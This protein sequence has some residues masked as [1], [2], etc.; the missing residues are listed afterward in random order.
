L[1][2]T[3]VPIGTGTKQEHQWG[4]KKDSLT[5]KS[6]CPQCAIK[7]NPQMDNKYIAVLSVM[8]AS[9]KII[10]QVPGGWLGRTRA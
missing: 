7:E 8:T 2:D 5:V 4:R 3:F 9:F 10:S 1:C 6:E